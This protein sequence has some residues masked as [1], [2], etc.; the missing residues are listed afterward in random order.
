MIAM[1]HTSDMPDTTLHVGRLFAAP[2]RVPSL[3]PSS[4][5]IRDGRIATI[6][7]L[8]ADSD[9]ARA[10][11]HLVALPAPVDAHDH[12]RGLR[13]VA[14]GAH[15]G[16]LEHWLAA[17]AREPVVDP[18]LRAATAFAAMVE[19]GV[20][21]ANHC[22]N[23]QV[24]SALFDEALAVSKAARDVGLRIAF[25][26]PFAGVNPSVYG[27]LGALLSR[28]DPADHAAVLASQ[29]PAR[30][31]AENLALTE[32]IAALE[33]P[34]FSVQYGPVGPQWVDHATLEA[35]A[36]ASAQ[37]GR[38]IHMHLFETRRQR[39]WADARYGQ[40]GLIAMLANIGFLSPRLTLAH[41]V[42]L[43]R[44]ECDV[45]AAHGV[46]VSLNTSS[47]LRLQSGIAPLATLRDS[48]VKF[49]VGLDGM[50]L[51]DDD[52]ML[53]ELRLLRHLHQANEYTRLPLATLFEAA[54]THGRATIVGD[55]GGTVETGMPADI[56]SIDLSRITADTLDLH[57]LPGT[58]DSTDGSERLLEL[59][60]TRMRKQDIDSLVVAG[61]IVVRNGACAS[62][63]RDA[64]QQAL[65]DNAREARATQTGP[66]ADPARIARLQAALSD[67][68]AC[69][70]HRIGA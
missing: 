68:Y 28:L 67:F 70:C 54:C 65:R 41:G 58:P 66:H 40:G 2:G 53:R 21:A 47:N 69:G 64:L 23:T 11:A 38:R 5:R 63:S 49:G 26:V 51:D 25:A 34:W 50:A 13:S 61:R 12:G 15:D 6:E 35:V 45:L 14:F 18:Y 62:V 42:W 44:D 19:G 46:T 22:H 60:L 48:G 1:D 43:T 56:L 29:T 55:G 16:P 7:A 36:E 10:V 52:D 57:D 8:T 39:E 17:L 32:R 24:G 27:N 31:L 3:G 59:L 37:T 9:A 20:C 4:I 33:H 30:S